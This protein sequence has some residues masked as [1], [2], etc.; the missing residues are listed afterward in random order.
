M[1]KIHEL[2][3]KISLISK[4]LIHNTNYNNQN[5]FNENVEYIFPDENYYRYFCMIDVFLFLLYR[6]IYS[7]EEIISEDEDEI[8]RKVIDVAML[9]WMIVCYIHYYLQ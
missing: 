6:Y 2:L 3:S 5:D 1:D 8:I 7:M 9:D 4:Q